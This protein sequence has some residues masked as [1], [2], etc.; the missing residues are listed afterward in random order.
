MQLPKVSVIIPV[1]NT[2]KYLSQCVKSV[3]QQTYKNLQIILVDDGSTDGTSV[4]CDKIKD[5]DSRIE[6]IHKN[7]EGLGL[8]RNKGL[9]YAVGEYV[10]FL[11]S[12]DWYELNHIENLVTV[13]LEKSSDLV[14]GSRTRYSECPKEVYKKIE[15]PIYGYYENDK[16]K[17]VVLPEIV[18]PSPTSH[19]DLGIP[20]SVCFNL[21][22]T[23][24]IRVNNL[25][26]V[27]ERY[28]VSEDFFFNYSYIKKCSKIMIV[29]EYGY[30]YRNT[31]MSISH[32]FSSEQI[33][34]VYNFY[35]E[36]Q[37]LVFS[38][39][40]TSDLK[41]RVYRC[42]L[43]K[44]RSLLHRLVTSS[45]STKQQVSYIRQ[46]I[47]SHQVKDMIDN[48]DYN[49]YRFSLKVFTICMKYKFTLLVY[50][51]LKLKAK[52]K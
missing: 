41:E 24:L 7:N 17:D 18:A 47:C 33:D 36:I 39:Q 51:L 31:P 10:T 15:L 27:S 43:S 52:N 26:F 16:I 28:C 25:C 19:L 21:Y 23:D 2:G 1:Y 14:I 20:M 44:V 5:Y 46:I 22:R 42:S 32:S 50:M 6:V 40:I 8:T 30:I 49:K 3:I 9:E 48:F 45:I 38:E 29:K 13:A 37:K 11:D 35:N 34:R 12:D 4:M